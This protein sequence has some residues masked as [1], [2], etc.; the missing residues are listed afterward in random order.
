MTLS[1]TAQ[2]Q[3]ALSRLYELRKLIAETEEAEMKTARL[4]AQASTAR[5]YTFYGDVDQDSIR[6]CMSEIGIWSREFPASPLTIIFNSPGGIVTE[7]LALY[8]YLL[9]LRSLG[10]TLTTIAMGQACS[11]GAVLLQA[12]DV[13]VVSPNVTMMIHELSGGIEGTVSKM[14]EDLQ[15]YKADNEKLLKILAARSTLSLATIKRR[16]KKTDLYLSADEAVKLGFADS[17]LA[18]NHLTSGKKRRRTS[19]AKKT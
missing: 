13:R 3:K 4:K 14:E 12:G 1:K 6:E 8:D 9:H 10:H 11:M 15:A 19:T 18:S 17:V 5:I 7:G 16:W 2:E